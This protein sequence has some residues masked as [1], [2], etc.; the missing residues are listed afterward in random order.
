MI[1]LSVA[2]PLFK[3]ARIAWLALEGLCYQQNVD[4][5]WELI[6]CEEQLPGKFGEELLRLY[7]KRLKKAGC[8]R[9]QYISQ[10]NWIPLSEKW[11]I[12]GANISKS[13]IAF[14]ICAADNFSPSK[15]LANSLQLIKEGADWV[16]HEKGIFYHLGSKK[17]IL[18]DHTRTKGVTALFMAFRSEY[19]RSLPKARKRRGVDSWLLHV[20]IAQKRSTLVIKNLDSTNWKTG[21][22]SHGLNTLSTRRGK[23]FEV[24]TAPYVNTKLRIA[25]LIPRNVYQKVKTIQL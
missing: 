9:V 5:E 13:S 18:Y 8:V 10:P 3:A 4:F 16:H 2:L 12:I 19:A 23:R 24:V 20:C 17:E 22:H 25:E 15:R 6:V 1:Q 11:R 21:F 7:E 14:V